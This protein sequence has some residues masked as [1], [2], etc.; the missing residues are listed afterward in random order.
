MTTSTDTTEQPKSFL[1][2]PVHGDIQH[3]QKRANQRPITE[4]QPLFQA[5]LDDPLIA[6]F[7]WTQYTPYFND[8]DP[9]TFRV[10]EAWFRTVSDTT[11]DDDEELGVNGYSKHPVLGEIER[12]Y[13][14]TYPNRQ[15]TSETYTGEHES[16]FRACLALSSALESDAFDDVLLEAFGDHARVV[17]SREGI[18]VEFY[19]HD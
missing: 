8:G 10:G 12:E 5:V 6:S 7:G 2:V 11:L 16:T 9:C 14:G 1:G 13:A 17:V 4:L 3:G 19:E 18:D 15:V